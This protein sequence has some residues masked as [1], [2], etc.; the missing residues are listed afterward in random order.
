MGYKDKEQQKKY[1]HQWYIDHKNTYKS[2][3][4]ERRK[5]RKKWF[6]GLIEGMECTYC[7]EPEI[8]CLSFHHL[9]PEEKEGGVREMVNDHRSK[10]KILAE[11]NKCIV[12]CE[13]CHRKIHAGILKI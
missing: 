3:N 10:E 4:Q 8:V 11:M 5:V 7:S 2:R 12:V 1:Q 6:R 9:N 13:N